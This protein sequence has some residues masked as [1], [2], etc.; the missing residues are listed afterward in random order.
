MKLLLTILTLLNFAYAD[1]ASSLNEYNDEVN[2]HELLRAA[3]VSLRDAR[4]NCRH[5]INSRIT[6]R[7]MNSSFRDLP[8]DSLIVTQFKDYELE[9]NFLSTENKA[10]LELTLIVSNSLEYKVFIVTDYSLENVQR[11]GIAR[12]NIDYVDY[13]DGTI[14][15]RIWRTEKES[16]TAETHVCAKQ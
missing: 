3:K 4:T 7:T 13:N 10:E 12:N 8:L 9:T 16:K 14:L 15:D 1:I 5:I 11:I 2:V 6:N